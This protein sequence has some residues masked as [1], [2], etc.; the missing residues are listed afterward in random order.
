MV[1]LG[2]F[3][4]NC[5]IKVESS[6]KD[7]IDGSEIENNRIFREI[8]IFSAKITNIFRSYFSLV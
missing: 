4:I 7:E 1:R 6:R 3:L 5:L 8:E 2:L